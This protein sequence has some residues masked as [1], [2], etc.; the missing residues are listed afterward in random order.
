MNQSDVLLSSNSI[1]KLQSFKRA[2]EHLNNLINGGF[3][4]LCVIQKLT[5]LKE[6]P[7]VQT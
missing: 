4:K 6:S 3:V 7:T 1:T 5:Y 2:V